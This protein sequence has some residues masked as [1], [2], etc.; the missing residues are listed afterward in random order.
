[1]SNSDWVTSIEAQTIILE[2]PENVTKVNFTKLLESI[3]TTDEVLINVETGQ[4]TIKETNTSPNP[5]P[6]PKSPEQDFWTLVA[7]C[8]REARGDAQGQADVAQSIYNRLGSK[9]YQKNSITGLITKRGEYSP[10]WE[11]PKGPERGINNP[12]WAWSNITNA[13]TAA[14]A[15]GLPG[16]ELF[17]VARNLQRTDLQQQ[18]AEFVQGRT[19]FFG[20]G[21]PAEAMTKNG[22]RKQRNRNSNQ[23][24]FSFNYTKN[25]TYPVPDFV[26]K[27]KLVYQ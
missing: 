22:S 3:N 23:F 25:V 6:A 11:Y 1:L 5:T 24:G 18:A 17:Q 2:D 14:A 27:I 15:T 26:N 8:A 4:T 20:V 7:I 13:T 10:T 16:D 19:D 12:N 9:A 21:Q